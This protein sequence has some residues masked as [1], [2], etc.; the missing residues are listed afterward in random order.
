MLVALHYN[1]SGVVPLVT[2]SRQFDTIS[3][4]DLKVYV[5]GFLKYAEHDGLQPACI[6][7]SEPHLNTLDDLIFGIIFFLLRLK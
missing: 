1:L 7:S 4:E 6:L 2:E 3:T 5:L